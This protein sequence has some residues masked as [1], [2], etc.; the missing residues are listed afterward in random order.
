[1]AVVV[2][3]L[4]LVYVESWTQEYG[5]F[6]MTTAMLEPEAVPKFSCL[7][8][9]KVAYTESQPPLLSGRYIETDRHDFTL[10]TIMRWR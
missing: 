5:G 4:V 1:M 7:A 10:R 9:T 8:K 3:W 6:A 2:I